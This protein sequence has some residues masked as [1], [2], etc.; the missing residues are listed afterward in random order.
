MKVSKHLLEHGVKVGN[1]TE[2]L[3]VVTEITEFKSDDW[4]D[5]H[6]RE[7]MGDDRIDFDKTVTFLKSEEKKSDNPFFEEEEGLDYKYIKDHW[8]Q[9][10][11]G[12]MVSWKGEFNQV[13]NVIKIL[14][15]G[16]ECKRCELIIFDPTKV[17]KE[18]LFTTLYV[19]D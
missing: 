3:N 1:L 8:Y 14:S 4:F 7:V 12:R 9:S 5:G 19:Y 16:S 10:Y 15:K 18:S 11:W 6:F 13:E 17:I 2:E